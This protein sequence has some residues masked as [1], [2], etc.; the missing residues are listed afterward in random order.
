MGRAGASGVATPGPSPHRVGAPGPRRCRP[1]PPRT[2]SRPLIP[3]SRRPLSPAGRASGR[4]PRRGNGTIAGLREPAAPFAALSE[5]RGPHADRSHARCPALTLRSDRRFARWLGGARA[6]R[7]GGVVAAPVRTP[8]VEAELVPAAAA[9]PFPARRS[10]VALRLKMR[11]G[12]HTYWRNPGDSGLPTTLDWKLPAGVKA[13]PIEWP[14]PHALPAGPLVNYGYEGEVLLPVVADGRAGRQAGHA[15]RHRRARRL[16]G[17]QGNLH[18]RRRRPRRW[19][20]RWRRAPRPHP[21]VGRAD[22]ATLRVAAAGRSPAGRPR[23]Q[24]DG[25]ARAA[26]ARRRLPAPPIRGSAALLPVRRRAHRGRRRRRR[27]RA[28]AT[29]TC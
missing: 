24:G 4:W 23:A 8:N 22:R 9:A 17:L 21:R 7:R 25:A 15:A 20:C 28:R 10:T 19:R 12:W 11:D 27:S 18:S 1:W 14:A 2:W 6:G 3:G 13:G 16:A 5:A 29:R 26:R